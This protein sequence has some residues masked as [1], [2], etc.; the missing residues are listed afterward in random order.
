MK[1]Q[2]FIGINA[3]D[4]LSDVLKDYS[5]KS[6]FL[7]T[8]KKSFESSGAQQILHNMLGPYNVVRFSDFEVNPK[9]EDIL[10]GIDCFNN[11]SCD[12]IVAIGGGSV[13]DIAKSINCFQANMTYKDILTG[14]LKIEAKGVPLL[15][16]PT[17][18]GT[19]SECTH[20]SVLYVDGIKYSLAHPFLLPDYAFVDPQFSYTT[21]RHIAAVVGM[22]AFCQAVESYWNIHSTEES[23]QYAG[24]AIQL[25]WSYLQKAVN[26]QD[27]YAIEQVSLGSFYAGK[28]INITKTTAPHALSYYLTSQY[29]VPHGQAVCVFLTDFL[30]FNYSLDDSSCQDSRGVVFVKERMEALFSFFSCQTIEQAV[31]AVSE[32]IQSLGLVSEF[33]DLK[34]PVSKRHVIN[35]VNLERVKNNPRNIFHYR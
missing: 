12:L 4:S 19:G 20:F 2:E 9:I 22:D 24:K 6:I 35:Q 17:T 15:A 14:D 10:K 27:K 28:A 31:Q 32:F 5:P 34:L 29:G 1:Q 11:H 26:N 33:S 30:V 23:L 7:V 21:P 13:I 8:G 18:S 25:L 3:I 16:I